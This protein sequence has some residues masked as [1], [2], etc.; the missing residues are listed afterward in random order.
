MITGIEF[1]TD[2]LLSKWDRY[3]YNVL[4]CQGFVEAVLKDV[5]RCRSSAL[6]PQPRGSGCG[7]SR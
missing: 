4:D 1:A 5:D 3:T 2:A 6:F 7:R